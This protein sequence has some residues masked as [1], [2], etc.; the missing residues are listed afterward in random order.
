MSLIYPE[1]RPS[2]R[3]YS[4][5][6]FPIKIFSSMNGIESRKLFGSAPVGG[7]L[8]LNYTGIVDTK[9]RDIYNFFISCKGNYFDFSL[10]DSCLSGIVDSSLREYILTVLR[11][12]FES[13]PT[14]TSTF[15]NKSDVSVSLMSVISYNPITNDSI[16][17]D[18]TAIQDQLVTILNS[19]EPHSHSYDT[20][21]NWGPVTIGTIDAGTI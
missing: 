18:L 4:P 19:F 6:M 9:V 2:A 13:P 5:P 17:G 14:I 11:W 21:N 1:I 12:R 15:N 16:G 7:K 8:S 10:S 20:P 3:S